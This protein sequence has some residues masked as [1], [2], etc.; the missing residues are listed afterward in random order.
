MPESLCDTIDLVHK[1]A[2]P[3][4]R[5]WPPGG[6]LDRPRNDTIPVS[7]TAHLDQAPPP[8]QQ[9]CGEVCQ[10]VPRSSGRRF[11]AQGQ[12]AD[13]G[14]LHIVRQGAIFRAGRRLE[15][16][17]ANR[18]KPDGDRHLPSGNTGCGTGA[19]AGGRG[20]TV[21]GSGSG[22]A[23]KDAIKCKP[24]W[25]YARYRFRAARAHWRGLPGASGTGVRIAVRFRNRATG[26]APDYI[27]RSADMGFGTRRW[28]G[29]LS[30]LRRRP[31]ITASRSCPLSPVM[32][33]P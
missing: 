11:V 23:T 10:L 4:R 1:S 17:D 6:G 21:A 9:V 22:H 7:Q 3:S 20:D 24:Q 14:G 25:P 18:I 2:S 26:T 30:K 33:R 32:A 19:A 15:L 16:L 8:Q 13:Q 27:W 28:R 31:K 29:L 5:W 12:V